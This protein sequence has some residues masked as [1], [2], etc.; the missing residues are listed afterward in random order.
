MKRFVLYR[1]TGM[2]LTLAII[3]ILG[4]LLSD[5]TRTSSE[6]DISSGQHRYLNSAEEKSRMV[7]RY[8]D[9]NFHLPPFYITMGSLAVPDSFSYLPVKKVR[10]L[11]IALSSHNGNPEASYK[12]VKELELLELK[13][14]D[15]KLTET[16]LFS[17]TSLLSAFL[18]DLVNN[19]DHNLA[20]EAR[21]L[22]YKLHALTKDDIS[23]RRWVPVI[24][25]TFDNR[26]HYWLFGNKKTD[27]VLQGNFG[28]SKLS[29]K[30]VGEILKKPFVI[31]F[32]IAVGVL[33]S[34][35]LFSIPLSLFLVRYRHRKIVRLVSESLI[36]V[37]AIPLFWMG[38]FFIFMFANPAVFDWLPSSGISPVY[39]YP[40]GSSLF[41]KLIIS[42]PYMVLPVLCLMYGAVIFITR[43]SEAGL[44]DELSKDYIKTARAKGLNEY[45][46]LKRHALRNSFLPVITVVFGALPVLISGS[47]LLENIFSIP[48][49]G[50]ALIRA[51]STEDYP[52]LT[53][54]FIVTGLSTVVAYA[55]SD[56]LYM[57]AD[58][59]IR[60]NPS[61]Q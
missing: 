2:L 30:P 53:A 61:I 29:G 57:Y 36:F 12:F 5:I 27:G 58:P 7:Q 14:P 39:G 47:V 26:F 23:Y 22:S 41:N 19:P 28:Y 24:N 16:S 18:K 3:A 37:Y 48:G 43:M 8:R 4:F 1:F 34:A 13:F 42:L 59:R 31:T 51:V 15:I 52:V 25:F 20:I 10:E 21:K 56:F 55:I 11:I 54:I 33:A 38:T 17:D 35:I 6:I 60:F 46:I 49:M 40:E 50:T 45:S 32:I 44:T 9:H